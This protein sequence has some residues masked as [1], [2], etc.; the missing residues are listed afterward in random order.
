MP[1]PATVALG[2]TL[3]VS[4]C[5]DVF[6][7]TTFEK[8]RQRAVPVEARRGDLAHRLRSRAWASLANLA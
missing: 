7:G 4:D 6:A 3:A 8:V 2:A 1:P 5:S